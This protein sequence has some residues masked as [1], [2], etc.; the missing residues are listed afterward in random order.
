MRTIFSLPGADSFDAI[1]RLW[2]EQV[3]YDFWKRS[4]Q[5]AW[6]EHKVTSF[7][8]KSELYED[9]N[10][11][12]DGLS[13]DPENTM[14]QTGALFAYNYLRELSHLSTARSLA[15]LNRQWLEDL[16]YP[17]WK[18]SKQTFWNQNN[19]T[20]LDEKKRDLARSAYYFS[21]RLAKNPN[22]WA[23]QSNV[24]FNYNYLSELAGRPTIPA[25]QE[26]DYD[27]LKQQTQSP[28][29]TA[30]TW[31]VKWLKNFYTY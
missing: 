5:E 3:T 25:T 23:Y 4:K 8:R 18:K 11:F 29:T 1:K 10:H 7:N 9:L 22:S 28:L 26:I 14:Y 24:L 30:Y 6:R 12:L 13:D 21:D 15:G 16:G 27:F 20:T 19:V 31:L 17:S 2:L